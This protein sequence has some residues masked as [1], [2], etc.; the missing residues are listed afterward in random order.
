MGDKFS[1]SIVATRRSR[2]EETSENKQDWCWRGPLRKDWRKIFILVEDETNYSTD[3]EME[4]QYRIEKGDDA[5]K[6]R[7]GIRFFY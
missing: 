1:S 4:N 5:K 3:A 2:I 6:I 7:K